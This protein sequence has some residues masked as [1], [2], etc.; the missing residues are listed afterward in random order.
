M[1]GQ[2]SFPFWG[3]LDPIFTNIMASQPTPLP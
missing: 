2:M 1:D 3:V